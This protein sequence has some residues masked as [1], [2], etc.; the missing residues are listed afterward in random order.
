MLLGCNGSLDPQCARQLGAEGTGR[1]WGP[2]LPWPWE[3]MRESTEGE[4]G[5]DAAQRVQGRSLSIMY[6]WTLSET[7]TPMFTTIASTWKQGA[8]GGIAY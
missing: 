5:R 6:K 1:F 3:G 2:R 7:C 8:E 4:A